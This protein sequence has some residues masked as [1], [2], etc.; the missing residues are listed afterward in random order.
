[1]ADVI[2]IVT[3]HSDGTST[4]WAAQP[5]V[6]VPPQVNPP[7]TN[8]NPPTKPIVLNPVTNIGINLEPVNYYMGERPF[9]DLAKTMS[10]IL[11]KKIFTWDDGPAITSFGKNGL[12]TAIP[13]GCFVASVIDLKK[14]HPNT[15]YSFYSPNGDVVCDSQLSTGVFR[16]TADEQRVLARINK[17]ISFWSFK[18]ASNKSSDTFAESFLERNKKYSVIRFMDWS[19]TNYDREV[20]WNTRVSRDWYTQAGKE[21]A[22]EYM[23]ELCNA[24]G[25]SPWYCVHHRADDVFVTELAKLFKKEYKSNKPI[26][27]EHSNEVWNS[28]FPQYEFCRSRSPKTGSPLEYS[29][30]RTA[31]IA[32]IFRSQGLN[33]VSVL[34]AQ[35]VSW[36]LMEWV[37]KSIPLP[38]DIDAFGIA[39]YFGYQILDAAKSSVDGIL[40]DAEK[41]LP[42]VYDNIRK[43]VDL[44]KKFNKKIVG[45]EGGQHICPF[46]YEHGNQNIINNFMAAN[47]SPRMYDLY[48]KYLQQ[49][50]VL[51]EKSL[52]CLFNSSQPFSKW[53]SWGLQEYEAQ[54]AETAHKFRAA[55]DHIS[56]K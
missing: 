37:L 33:V 27:L 19:K 8:P 6:V 28:I 35:S 43:W 14:G 29:I 13:Q 15:D 23:I 45:Y 53:G 34:G 9:N 31:Q 54:P 25:S 2:K 44:G 56:G 16:K 30:T 26:Y 18:E 7:V 5:S 22:V 38:T 48:R 4:T 11:C 41:S 32:K 39:P 21:V 52:L 12:P 20:T 51:T 46:P 55:M 1:M 17:P 50:D 40:D 42:T 36:G 24:T 49:W 10:P 3:Y 47:R